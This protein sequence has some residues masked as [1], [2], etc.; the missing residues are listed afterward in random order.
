MHLFRSLPI[1]Q[2]LPELAHAISDV[3]YLAN[4]ERE[5]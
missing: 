4:I 3:V 2:S 5:D 1:D